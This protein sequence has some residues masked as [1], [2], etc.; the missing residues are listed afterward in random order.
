MSSLIRHLCGIIH[1]DEN[2]NK[3]ALLPLNDTCCVAQ[4][5]VYYMAS[6][7]CRTIWIISNDIIQENL[8]KVVGDYI[9]DPNC[10]IIE[11]SKIESNLIPVYYM[12]PPV[13]KSVNIEDT[14]VVLSAF[15][16]LHKTSNAVSNFLIP[17]KWAITN[18]RVIPH[19]SDIKSLKKRVLLENNLENICIKGKNGKH[20]INIFLNDDMNLIYKMRSGKR[21][22][23]EMTQMHELVTCTKIFQDNCYFFEDFKDYKNILN[24]ETISSFCFPPEFEKLKFKDSTGLELPFIGKDTKINIKTRTR[25]KNDN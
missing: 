23:F 1:I 7:G 17:S 20:N 15:K 13:L 19:I 16:T 22:K 12:R 18:M 2:F 8:K 10:F 14:D 24:D 3:N 4:Y 11:P 25:S 21:M 5:V 9:P 6:L